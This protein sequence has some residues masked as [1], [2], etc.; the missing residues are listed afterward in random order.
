[1]TAVAIMQPYLFPYIGYWQ[2]LH[3]ADCFVVYDDVNYINRGWINRNRIL[4][5]DAPGLITL[6]L[7]QAS[8]NRKIC[9][10]EIAP[11]TQWQ[12]RLLRTL[13]MAYRK[14]PCFDQ[15][16]P[17]VEQILIHDDSNLA[18]FLTHQ[19]RTLAGF[20]D[21]K[22]RIVPSSQVYGNSPLAAQARILDICR[23]EQATTYINAQGG[24]SLYEP[25]AFAERGIE[26][27]FIAMHSL[28]YPQRGEGFTPYLSI[29]DA[30][31]E[32]GPDGIAPHLAAYSL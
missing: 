32:V 27:R 4:I 24:R 30:L 1:M 8:Q 22:T 17:V 21:L 28:P 20:M 3:A 13:E 23:Q 5:N 19:L 16:F 7:L 25:A 15:V 2:L 12:R 14:A 29:I 11:A 26:L 9:D 10:I 18:G 6:P 31:M